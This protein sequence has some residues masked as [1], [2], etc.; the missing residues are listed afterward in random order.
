MCNGASLDRRALG[1]IHARYDWRLLAESHLTRRLL[2]RRCS[3]S[4]PASLDR[5]TGAE[6]S[7]KVGKKGYPSG[8]LSGKCL[9]AVGLQSVRSACGPSLT[10]SEAERLG[11]EKIWPYVELSF[12]K[13]AALPFGGHRDRLER[14]SPGDRDHLAA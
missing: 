13:T 2:G 4:G 11:D 8:G 3:G 7:K 6:F 12:A 14:W 10:V 9:G 1:E 5:L